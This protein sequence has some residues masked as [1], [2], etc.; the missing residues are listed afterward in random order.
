MRLN[1]TLFALFV[2]QMIAL[3][4][5]AQ[6]AEF[7]R[8]NGGTIDT[9]TKAPRRTSGSLAL[10]HSLGGSQGEGYEGT[11]GGEL[12]EDR[13]WFFASASLLS[14]TE[15]SNVDV[16]AFDAKATAQPVDWTSVTASFRQLQQPTFSND[17]V[18]SSF[19]SLRSTSMLSDSMMMDF[20]FSRS[21]RTRSAFDPM[22]LD[23]R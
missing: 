11:L 21:T 20:S 7:G 18:P 3:A 10:T 8:A 9:I 13:I 4:A 12:L 2:M 16:P 1:R 17:T 14:R 5:V 6:S 22:P 19:L 15:L 23:P